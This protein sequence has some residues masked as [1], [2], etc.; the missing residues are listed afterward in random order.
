M[1]ILLYE[2]LE[3]IISSGLYGTEIIE[4]EKAS[5]LGLTDMERPSILRDQ[6]RGATSWYC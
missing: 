3:E 4:K 1:H 5:R 2:S 6:R